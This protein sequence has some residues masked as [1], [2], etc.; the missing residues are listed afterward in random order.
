MAFERLEKSFPASAV[1]F[2]LGAEAVLAR[3]RTGAR[4]LRLLLVSYPTPQLAAKM[5]R[6][7]QQLPAVAQAEAD[8]RV[9]IR[10][11]G[12]LLGFVFD[13]PESAAAEKLLSRISY[14]SVVTWNEF[15]PSARDNVGDMV[16][17]I[18]LLAGFL[19][20]FAVVA[21]ISFGA[22]RVLAKKFLPMPIFDRPSQVEIIRLNLTDK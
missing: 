12:P 16:Y 11:K 7:F 18:F 22:F 15:V 5:L 10:R 21:G 20:L 6:S 17:K 4:D 3:Y 13:A 19:L 14:E 2:D 9:Y 8:R 1:G